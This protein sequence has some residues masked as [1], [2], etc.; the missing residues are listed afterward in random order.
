MDFQDKYVIYVYIDTSIM[1]FFLKS[2]QPSIRMTHALEELQL[3]TT[4][5]IYCW[6]GN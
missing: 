3:D 6:C 5:G 2:F 4:K 1:Q